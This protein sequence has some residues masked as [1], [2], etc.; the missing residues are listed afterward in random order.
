MKDKMQ[1]ISDKDSCDG[2]NGIKYDPAK[3][4]QTSNNKFFTDH[5]GNSCG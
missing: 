2:L 4:D 3:K 1:D 5:G